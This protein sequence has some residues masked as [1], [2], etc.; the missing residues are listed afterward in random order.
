MNLQSRFESSGL[1]PFENYFHAY[2][3]SLDTAAQ[4]FEPVFKGMARCQLEVLGLMSRRAQAYLDLAS[5]MTRCRGPQDFASASLQF[6]QTAFQHYTD[7][8]RQITAACAQMATAPMGLAAC[9]GAHGRR[10]YI[11]FA[12]DEDAPD[13][14]PRGVG[15]RQAA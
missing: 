10:D 6:W 5:S 3:S 13:A 7:S 15:E 14:R 9:G 1:G 12:T 4:T 8:S 2:S 11:T